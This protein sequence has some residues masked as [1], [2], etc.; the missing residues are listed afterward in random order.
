[1]TG[2]TDQEL[3][4][5]ALKH[6]SKMIQKGCQSKTCIIDTIFD[7]LKEATN[8]K[9]FDGKRILLTNDLERCPQC[10][11]RSSPMGKNRIKI[12]EQGDETCYYNCPRCKGLVP[13][14]LPKAIRR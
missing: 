7:A 3:K 1:M 6:Y 2:L 8:P 5:I 11:T 12:K 14:T 9:V 10:Q 4:H 13:I